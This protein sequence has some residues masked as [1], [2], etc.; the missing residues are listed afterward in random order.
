MNVLKYS[1]YINKKPKMI[2]E[3]SD[4]IPS[5]SIQKCDEWRIIKNTLLLDLLLIVSK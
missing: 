5:K 4:H 2:T 3:V 1:R